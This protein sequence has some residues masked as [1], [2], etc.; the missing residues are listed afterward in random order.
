[1]LTLNY[2]DTKEIVTA[3][4]W[5]EETARLAPLAGL[6][7]NG[8]PRHTDNLGWLNPEE[9]AGP[10]QL[11]EIESLA[12][13]IRKEAD[14]FV[15]IG[16][17]GS[18]N[19]ARAAISALQ[20]PGETD[21]V[22][23]GNTLSPYALRKALER[24]EGKSV[25]VDCIAKNFET[26]EP[27][28]SFRLLR[29]FLKRQYGTDADRRI[30]VT[31]TPGSPLDALAQKHGWRFMAFPETVGGRYSGLTAVGL[32]PMAVAGLN[33]RAMMAGAREIREQLLAA[34][35]EE[36]LALRYACL[37]NMLYRKG[38]KLEM[39]S[40]FEPQF[41]DFFRWWRQLFAESEGKDGRGIFPVAAEDSEDLHSIGQYVQDGEPII[42]ESFLDVQ[43]PNASLW[44][45]PDGVDDRFDYLNDKD[46]WT[47][48][49]IAFEATRE[50]HS[51]KLP[52]ITL[53]VPA[54]DERTLGAL[55][56]FYPCVCYLSGTILGI[57]P[58]DQPGVEAYKGY[59]FKALGKETE[60]AN[61]N[62]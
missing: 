59:M 23:M 28:A 9:C 37:R 13:E 26:L 42:F 5:E 34:K 12:A 33:I 55:Y 49:K 6:L 10:K 57:D 51:Q 31:G 1:M 40:A 58:F 22:Y 61:E 60:T 11:S 14:V 32:L 20:K 8:E 46:F 53:G 24:L 4:E 19:A 48:N 54:L 44:P 56:Y 17:G 36:N 7:K 38:Y 50:A 3:A 18:N 52:C 35:P 62:S 21:I 39:L 25:Y 43:T 27:G 2:R 41:N 15:V 29:T 45:E 16:I 30:V 47:I